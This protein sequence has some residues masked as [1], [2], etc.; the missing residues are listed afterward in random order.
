MPFRHQICRYALRTTDIPAAR[1]FYTSVL[2]E[3]FSRSGVE[4]I[5]LPERARKLGA[6]SHFSGYVAVEEADFDAKL[7]ALTSRGAEQLGPT[8]RDDEG[9]RRAWL[10]DPFGAR[11]GLWDGLGDSK[12]TMSEQGTLTPGPVA[13]HL[14]HTTDPEEALSFYADLFGWESKGRVDLGEGRGSHRLFAWGAGGEPVG[15]FTDLARL[16]HVHA[17]WLYCFPTEDIESAA[18]T[19]RAKGGVVAGI[20]EG[21][22][23][24]R[25]AGCD[26]PQGAAFA[27]IEV[28][29]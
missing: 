7:A 21:Q 26:D 4:V 9:H 29:R 1:A 2:G 20:S 12:Q 24:H 22:T 15:S 14:L 27:L 10:R 23:G 28:R 16:P 25:F 18:T 13:W 19:V 17:Q 6:P 3:A 8:T 11:I 5:P